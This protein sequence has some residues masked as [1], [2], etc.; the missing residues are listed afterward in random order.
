MLLRRHHQQG[1][2]KHAPVLDTQGETMKTLDEVR[3]DLDAANQAINYASGMAIGDGRQ[4]IAL[5]LMEAGE[6]VDA[7]I[8]DLS[9]I[10][11]APSDAGES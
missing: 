8:D 6:I 7:A 2:G 3:N 1:Q 5:K 10:E 4:D 9:E 11:H